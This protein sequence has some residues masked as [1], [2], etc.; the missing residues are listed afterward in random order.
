MARSES[1]ETNNGFDGA[2]SLIL[3]SVPYPNTLLQE[4]SPPICSTI[5]LQILKPRPVPYL[6]I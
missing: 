3:N 6:L 2:V 4:T 5:N 1:F